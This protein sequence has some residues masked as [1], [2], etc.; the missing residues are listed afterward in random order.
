V[1]LDVSMPDQLRARL[2]KFGTFADE[3]KV[4]APRP[5]TR[6]L[7]LQIGSKSPLARSKVEVKH[8]TDAA[9]IFPNEAAIT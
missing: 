7:R 2:P 9:G 4:L 6:A 1:V 3:A 5:V 8:P